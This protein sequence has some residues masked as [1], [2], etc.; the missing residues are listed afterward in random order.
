MEF[1]SQEYWNELP[2]PPP[3]DLPYAG[4]KPTFS[5]FPELE[6]GLFTFETPWKPEC[7]VNIK[8]V[9]LV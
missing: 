5:A 1:L 7:P 8:E 9:Y 3:E 6:S 4:I 2:F